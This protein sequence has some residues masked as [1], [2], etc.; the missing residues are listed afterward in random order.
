M[1]LEIFAY[2]LL[3]FA[4]FFAFLCLFLAYICLFFSFTSNV[5]RNLP[6]FQNVPYQHADEKHYFSKLWWGNIERLI[7]VKLN[8]WVTLNKSILPLTCTWP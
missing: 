3:F 4:F 7:G 6:I 1:F 2:F 5:P 8:V